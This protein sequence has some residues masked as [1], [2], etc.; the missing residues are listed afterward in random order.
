MAVFLKL[1]GIEGESQDSR[2]AKEIDV[3]AWS[4]GVTNPGSSHV[5]G[6]MGAGRAT[7]S[8]L[9]VTKMLD[10]ASPALLLA[11]ASGRHIRTA[12]LTV[13]SG[14]PRPLEYLTVD[15]EDVLVTSCLLADSA[16][17]DRPVENV[18][19]D[20]GKIRVNY[21][22]QSPT[23]AIGVASTFGWDVVRNAPA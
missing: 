21:S 4:L 23:G 16:D 5:G 9:S 8:D 15:L 3:S 17:P 10:K 14:G 1:D 7:F 19:F 20:Y 18:A 6:G 2:H 12:K 11:V 22:Q 13:T